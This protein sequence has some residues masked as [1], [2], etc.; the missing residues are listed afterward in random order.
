MCLTRD[1]SFWFHLLRFLYL[2]LHQYFICLAFCVSLLHFDRSDQTNASSNLSNVIAMI[3]QTLQVIWVTWLII[4]SQTKIDQVAWKVL[5]IFTNLS[6]FAFTYGFMMM[7]VFP[8]LS[9]KQCWFLSATNMMTFLICVNSFMGTSIAIDHSTITSI[10]Y[11]VLW[12]WW[13]FHIERSVSQ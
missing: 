6:F 4:S 3:R 8:T 1:L 9:S 7:L 12:V 13:R 5:I 10:Q 11:C 2:L